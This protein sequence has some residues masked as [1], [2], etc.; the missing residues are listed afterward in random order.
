MKKL[1]IS[2][3][4]FTSFAAF[5]QEEEKTEEKKGF[6]P[7]NLFTGGSITFSLGGYDNGFVAGL[8]P[9][10]G[11]TVAKWID[12]AA[13]VNYQYNSFHDAVNNKYRSTVYGGGIFTRI[14]P[15]HFIF[16][17]AQPEYNFIR[18]KFIPVG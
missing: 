14:F 11:Y 17:Q 4:L 1:F 16:I 2:L 6:D 10:F 3:L 12:F 15:V 5:A 9:H 7:T 18:Y 13:V 8:N